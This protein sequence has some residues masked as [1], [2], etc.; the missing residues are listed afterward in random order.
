MTG[1]PSGTREKWGPDFNYF[2]LRNM[3]I[4]PR[5]F[6]YVSKLK[7]KNR[8]QDGFVFKKNCIY[9]NSILAARHFLFVTL[10]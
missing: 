1:L 9:E 8:I 10:L 7:S 2:E 5:D 6:F 3:C 4:L